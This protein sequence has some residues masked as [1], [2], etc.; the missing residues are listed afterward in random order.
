MIPFMI[1]MFKFSFRTYKVN[2]A[3]I[4]E[5]LYLYV[6]I[7]YETHSYLILIIFFIATVYIMVR[8]KNQLTRV[9]LYLFFSYY[10]FYVLDSYSVAVDRYTLSFVPAISIFSG[11]FISKIGSG[12]KVFIAVASVLLSLYLFIISTFLELPEMKNYLVQ[13]KNYYLQHYPM[14]KAMKWI[15]KEYDGKNILCLGL[16]GYAFYRDKYRFKQESI[17]VLPVEKY[18][19][20]TDEEFDNIIQKNNISLILS[21]KESSDPYSRGAFNIDIFP[22]LNFIFLHN[23]KYKNNNEVTI[24]IR[25]DVES[26]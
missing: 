6:K 15:R 13:Y 21:Y 2:M 16:P 11:I 14:D 3:I 24:F 5:K 26:S 17:T 1:T 18:L 23:F 25:K 19:T 8:E 10:L 7:I 20:M 12:K 9:L 4:P 22:K